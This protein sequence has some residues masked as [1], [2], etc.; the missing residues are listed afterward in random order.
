MISSLG[1][2][3]PSFYIEKPLKEETFDICMKETTKP[4]VIKKLYMI[5]NEVKPDYYFM[6][7]PPSSGYF[8][9]A[10]VVPAYAFIGEAK[11]Q[12]KR[13]KRLNSL[14]TIDPSYNIRV[15]LYEEHSY[16]KLW[17]FEHITRNK[18]QIYKII[19]DLKDYLEKQIKL[20]DGF[21][22]WK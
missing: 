6:E 15:I 9:T 4:P 13:E 11:G 21:K 8:L 14:L 22:V 1:I 7:L 17:E 16:D 3:L 10:K 18:N 5:A 20:K 12:I 19:I 2:D